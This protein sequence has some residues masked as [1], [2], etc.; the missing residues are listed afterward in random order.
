MQQRLYIRPTQE[1]A[2][3]AVYY[4]AGMT[5]D[6]ALG[7]EEGGPV[8]VGVYVLDH[9]LIAERLIHVSRKGK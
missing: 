9:V 2:G 4:Q 5:V 6:A 7:D 8:E 1:R 3:D